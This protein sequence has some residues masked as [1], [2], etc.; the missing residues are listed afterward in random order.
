M[1]HMY[2]KISAC[3]ALVFKDIGFYHDVN[4]SVSTV[5]R[6]FLSL[7]YL[8]A[9]LLFTYT[10]L[11]LNFD[12]YGKIV[13]SIGSAGAVIASMNLYYKYCKLLRI[14]LTKA[15]ELDN[16]ISDENENNPEDSKL[17]L[18]YKG[19]PFISLDLYNHCVKRLLPV[20]EEVIKFLMLAS[21]TILILLFSF[22]VTLSVE[23]SVD[24]PA[25]IGQVLLPLFAAGLLP[26]IARIMTSNEEAL[27]KDEAQLQKL[28]LVLKNY[29]E[30]E[31]K[32]EQNSLMLNA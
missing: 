24:L 4:I 27:L 22:G 13:T 11:F 15:Q 21:C 3:S 26:L 6:K 9:I 14:I 7:A 5:F 2:C 23:S 32:G 25:V 29:K 12:F 18:I 31:E 19:L 17:I 20:M 1:L 8:S 10:G 16:A 30:P 28:E